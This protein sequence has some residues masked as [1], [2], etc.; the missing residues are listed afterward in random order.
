MSGEPHAPRRFP[1]AQLRDGENQTTTSHHAS[2]LRS[3]RFRHRR[4]VCPRHSLL[5]LQ[6]RVAAPQKPSAS[7]REV[8]TDVLGALLRR[9]RVA[10]QNGRKFRHLLPHDLAGLKF[11]GRACWNDEAAAGLI[12]VTA[13][14]R[15]GQ[16]DFENAEVTQ[17]H[18]VALREGVGDVIEGPL[19]NIEYL[20]LNQAGFVADLNDEF[21]FR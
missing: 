19:D 13:D 7:S 1:V 11:Y 17:F 21:P 2:V 14:T 5:R 12:G 10:F 3:P 8:G 6:G 4:R 18:G 9:R 20:M 15:L 16:F